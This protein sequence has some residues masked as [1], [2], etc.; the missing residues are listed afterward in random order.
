M[1]LFRSTCI[2]CM[3]TIVYLPVFL[4]NM[5]SFDLQSMVW[6]DITNKTHGTQPSPRFAHGFASVQSQL[7]VHMG[8]GYYGLINKS[9]AFWLH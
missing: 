2:D 4:S 8:S 3:V 9:H 6:E 1:I 7:Y 5:L